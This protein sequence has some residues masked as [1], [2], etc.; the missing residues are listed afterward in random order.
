[1]E[2][3]LASGVLGL[4]YLLKSK[5]TL[6]DENKS[7]DEIAENRIPSTNNIYDSNYSKLVQ[8][9]VEER[10]NNVF[11]DSKRPIETNVIPQNFMKNIV[12]THN[13]PDINVP[14][15]IRIEERVKVT[16]VF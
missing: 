10:A 12:N 14:G 7:K 15:D 9:R 6:H 1:M 5:G 11:Q 2:V 16:R 13:E 8:N 3:V 4:G